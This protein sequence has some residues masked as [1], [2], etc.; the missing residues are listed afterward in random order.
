MTHFVS[1]CTVATSLW[2]AAAAAVSRWW[3]WM[4]RVGCR[5]Q[6]GEGWLIKW[7]SYRNQSSAPFFFLR[8]RHWE[9]S[10]NAEGKKK[11]SNM[12]RAIILPIKIVII[13]KSRFWDRALQ[14]K[15]WPGWISSSSQRVGWQHHNTHSGLQQKTKQT[16]D[17]GR[18]ILPLCNRNPTWSSANSETQVWLREQTAWNRCDSSSAFCTSAVAAG[19]LTRLPGLAG[20]PSWAK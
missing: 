16:T 17:N 20:W 12:L 1:C 15:Q 3:N 13:L 19:P 9:S 8:T 2:M 4:A 7:A 11:R 18:L 6:E 5:A 14:L 10:K